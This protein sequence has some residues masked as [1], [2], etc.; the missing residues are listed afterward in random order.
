MNITLN[1][2]PKTTKS[3]SIWELIQEL[4]LKNNL[5]AVAKND[6]ILAKSN[7]DKEEICDG[8]KIDIIVPVGGG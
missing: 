6:K 5:I 3:K 7:W 8:D 2:K 4:N 1:D